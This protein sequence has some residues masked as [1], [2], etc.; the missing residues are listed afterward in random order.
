MP[1]PVRRGLPRA[2]ALALGMALGGGTA[3]ARADQL[4]AEIGDDERGYF[5]V[6]E[7]SY[8][9]I[10]D[11]DGDRDD[12]VTL[13]LRVAL[14]NTSGNPRDVVH[15]LALPV[16]AELVGLQIARDGT[17]HPGSV[18]TLAGTAGPRDPARS[19]PARSTPR[20]RA[21]RQARSSRSGSSP[22]ARSRSS[23]PCG[24]SRSCGAGDGSSSCPRA[25]P[26][27]RPWSPSVA[28]SCAGC[29]RA[30]RSSSTTR[31]AARSRR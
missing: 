31:P 14:L 15:T 20:R 21:C 22:D 28:C 4:D 19:G 11:A 17:W 23:W 18:T 10:V 27:N 24:C 7:L 5:P 13:R 6:Q 16:G 3:I 8:E 29:R 25:D 2:L 12:A 30:S 1:S 9:A 26:S